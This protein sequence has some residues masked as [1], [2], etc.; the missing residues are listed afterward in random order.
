MATEQA[1]KLPHTRSQSQ[2]INKNTTS[3]SVLNDEEQT[4]SVAKITKQSDG[5]Q[6]RL[7]QDHSTNDKILIGG[8]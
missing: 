8:L 7:M 4:V 3:F 2:F 5:K 6:A 1:E